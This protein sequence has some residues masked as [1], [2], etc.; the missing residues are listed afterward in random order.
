MAISDYVNSTK[1]NLDYRLTSNKTIE[2]LK[3]HKCKKKIKKISKHKEIKQLLKKKH[4][5]TNNT[6]YHNH[7][8]EWHCSWST[9]DGGS[10]RENTDTNISKDVAM[11]VVKGHPAEGQHCR[12]RTQG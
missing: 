5:K 11:T 6:Q 1:Q 2:V 12:S 4:Q 7:L 8:S 10:V 3:Y 9:R